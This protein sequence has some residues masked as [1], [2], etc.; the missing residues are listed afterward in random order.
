MELYVYMCIYIL[1]NNLKFEFKLIDEKD[2][3][4][5]FS[6]SLNLDDNKY[7]GNGRK[8]DGII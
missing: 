4:K 3:D 7:T 1:E 6:I 8:K 2:P 5:L